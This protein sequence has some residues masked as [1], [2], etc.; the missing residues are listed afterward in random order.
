M[1]DAR[2]EWTEDDSTLY[3]ELAAVAVPARAEQIATLLTLLPFGRQES[4]HAV[5]VGCGEGALS[6]AILDAFPQATMTALDGSAQMRAHTAG[7]LA[8]FGARARVEEFDLASTPWLRHAEG[9]G[10]VV[11]S[12]CV[13][14]LPAAG[15][16]RL[17][18][19]V[20]TRLSDRG[21]LLIADLI[22]PQR[23][24]AGA[25]FAATWDRA[26][27][28][29]SLIETGSPELFGRFVQTQ[30]NYFRFPDPFDQPSP[31]FDQLTWLRAAGFAVADCF[32]LQAGHAIYGGYK[33]REEATGEAG[34][35]FLEALA[36][37]E[38][39]LRAT[40]GSAQAST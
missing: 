28:T 15:K 9:A 31:L 10:C 16:Q 40:A 38:A 17:F 36:T 7:R 26:A 25:L 30:W 13:H 27:E 20:A 32:W 8:H 14:H 21:A 37:A 6:Y 18:A 12:L 1:A 29:Q 11:S 19:D 5:E 35:A 39:A 23:A 24:E 34:I 3:Q 4:F 33:Q 2:N 22:A